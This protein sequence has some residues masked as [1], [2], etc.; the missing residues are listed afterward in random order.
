MCDRDGVG[1][2]VWFLTCNLTCD[3]NFK[4]E[5]E[6][7]SLLKIYNKITS[8]KTAQKSVFKTIFAICKFAFQ[9]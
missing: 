2:V 9:V 4:L 6:V 8:C 7:T 1:H 5:I 3:F